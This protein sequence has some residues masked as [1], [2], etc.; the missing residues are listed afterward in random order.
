[1]RACRWCWQP[2]VLCRACDRGHVY[3]SLPCRHAGRARSLRAA[4]RRHQQ[5]PEGRLDHRD[6]QRAYRARC[7]ARVTHQTSPA[8]ASCGTLPACPPPMPMEGLDGGEPGGSDAPH[9]PDS[10]PDR[11]PRCACCGRRGRFLRWAE[12][13]ARRGRRWGP[14][15]RP[16]P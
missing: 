2:F 12:A 9:S 6:H 1:M 8:A 7:R 10:S 14:R 15:I 11:G 16:D 3:C 5:S 13:H 4:G